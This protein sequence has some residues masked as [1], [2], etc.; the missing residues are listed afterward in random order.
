MVGGVLARAPPI[1][2]R[3]GGRALWG[4]RSEVRGEPPRQRQACAVTS[5]EQFLVLPDSSI[6][7]PFTTHCCDAVSH[8]DRSEPSRK[9]AS[10]LPFMFILMP[11]RWSALTPSKT[12]SAR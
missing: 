9:Y 4:S 12:R 6:T 11:G 1:V 8:A 7:S 10:A 3:A 2:A 5:H